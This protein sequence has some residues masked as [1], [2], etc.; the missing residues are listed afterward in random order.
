MPMKHPINRYFDEVYWINTPMRKERRDSLTK[1]LIDSGIQATRIEAIDGDLVRYLM[2]PHQREN[3][4]YYV[5]CLLSHLH[6]INVAYHAGHEHVLILE[7]DVRIHQDSASIF[8]ELSQ[9]PV[10]RDRTWDFLYLGFIPVSDDNL[11][12]DY[13]LVIHEGIPDS[14]G[15]LRANKHYTGAY[16]YAINRKMMKFLLENL[17][18]Y[19]QGIWGV[20]EWLRQKFYPNHQEHHN[21][22]L[23]P[24]IFAHDNGLSTT[25]GL[26]EDRMTRSCCP[27]FSTPDHYI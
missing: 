19:D 3:H 14:K 20:D 10:L 25:N 5:S 8:E 17:S 18:E 4:R 23:V 22:G 11:V 16:A 15:V 12:W 21:Y 9:T 1:R 27:Y 13:T 26:I 2:L 24:Q 7:D 6:T